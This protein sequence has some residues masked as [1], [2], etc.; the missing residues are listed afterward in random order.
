MFQ[1]SRDVVIGLA[2]GAIIV[3]SVVAGLKGAEQPSDLLI[4]AGAVTALF[5]A[6]AFAVSRY[7]SGKEA[8]REFLDSDDATSQKLVQK[9]GLDEEFKEAA[10]SLIKEDNKIWQEKINTAAATPETAARSSAFAIG[11]SFAAA[12]TLAVIPFFIYSQTDAPITAV[13]A[14]SIVLIL[15]GCIKARLAQRNMLAGAAIQWG[16]GAVAIGL[17]FL[18]GRLLG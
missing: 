2:D 5:G 4:N 15:C 3:S 14:V 9:L 10:G 17:C 18:M 8:Q 12:G 7:S 11:F 1:T 13:I 16:T 6:I